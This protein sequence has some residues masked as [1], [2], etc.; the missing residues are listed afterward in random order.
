VSGEDGDEIA[1]R[2]VTT[3]ALSFDHRHVDG[4]KGSRFLSD[5]AGILEDP[6]SALLF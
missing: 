2:Q 6:A 3:L 4:E 1:V 5:V